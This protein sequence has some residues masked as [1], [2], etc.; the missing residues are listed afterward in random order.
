LSNDGIPIGIFEGEKYLESE[1][2]L[3]PGDVFIAYTDGIPEARNLKKEEFGFEGIKEIIRA[4]YN[5]SAESIRNLLINELNSFVGNAP[6][7]DDI[8]SLIIKF[9][10]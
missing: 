5:Q 4:N 7:H 10:E 1:F 3:I 2:E 6:Q 9:K 8:T